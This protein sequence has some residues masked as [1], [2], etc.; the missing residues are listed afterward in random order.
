MEFA[1]LIGVFK[2]LLIEG[3]ALVSFSEKE[4]RD[5]AAGAVNLMEGILTEPETEAAAKGSKKEFWEKELMAEGTWVAIF[6]DVLDLLCSRVSLGSLTW[7]NWPRDKGNF[8]SVMELLEWKIEFFFIWNNFNLWLFLL[9]F[10]CLLYAI[11]D[12][13]GRSLLIL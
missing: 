4:A 8:F 10:I 3:K 7:L 12:N 2:I 11:L 9:D 6:K 5:D 13:E 1:R